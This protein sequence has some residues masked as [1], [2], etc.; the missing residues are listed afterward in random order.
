MSKP[1]VKELREA[2]AARKAQRLVEQDEQMEKAFGPLVK[3]TDCGLSFRTRDD[4]E[5]FKCTECR[6]LASVYDLATRYGQ[7]PQAGDACLLYKNNRY[8][9]Y[10]YSFERWMYSTWFTDWTQAADRLNN[11]RTLVVIAGFAFY[12]QNE[13][14]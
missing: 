4:A 7:H 12:R 1:T 13:E 11:Y 9:L 3:C 8:I 2:R 10:N 6:D 5:T 14:Q